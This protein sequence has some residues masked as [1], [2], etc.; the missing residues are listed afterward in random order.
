MSCCRVI[1]VSGCFLLD[2]PSWIC[3]VGINPALL[4]VGER[5]L[6]C[7]EVG[8]YGSFGLCHKTIP[9]LMLH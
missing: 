9:M 3:L 4:M 8:D 6:V 7:S 2:V 5:H 1:S